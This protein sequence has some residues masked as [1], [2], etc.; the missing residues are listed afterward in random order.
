VL[1]SCAWATGQVLR[2]RRS[3]QDWL[4]GFDEAGAAFGEAWRDLITDDLTVPQQAQVPRVLNGFSAFALLATT[5]A[6]APSEICD[7]D[8]AVMVPSLRYTS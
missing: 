8:P 7:A 3:R 2:Q 5:T 6:A 4:S 1:S